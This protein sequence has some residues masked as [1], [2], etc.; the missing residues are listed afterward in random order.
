MIH[1]EKF[2]QSDYNRLINWI[3]SEEQMVLFSGQIFDY[4]ITN[5]QLDRY[6][7]CTDRLVYKAIQTDTNEVIGHAELNAINVR[8][9]SARICRVLIGD[10]NARNKGIGSLIIKELVRIGF[11]ELKLHRIDLGVHDFNTQAL[12]CYEKCGFKIEGLLKDNM[13]FGTEFWSSYNM[14]LLNN[15][16]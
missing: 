7:D 1:L 4:P 9:S 14:S 8:S 3:T 15:K 11:T 5:S 12:K 6:L 16:I 2:N 10:K 13:K